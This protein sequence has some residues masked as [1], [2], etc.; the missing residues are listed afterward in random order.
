MLLVLYM[1]ILFFHI[2]FF[3]CLSLL[4]FVRKTKEKEKKKE[5]RN[6]INCVEDAARSVENFKILEAQVKPS[7]GRPS[8]QKASTNTIL[9]ECFHEAKQR[10]STDVGTFN[11]RP[12][13]EGFFTAK[14]VG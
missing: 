4:I 12:C 6:L 8:Q 7:R 10:L 13:V 11:S 5:K 2:M 3:R 9:P 14:R 1:C